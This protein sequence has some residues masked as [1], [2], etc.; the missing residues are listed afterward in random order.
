MIIE[1]YKPWLKECG[2]VKEA[3]RRGWFITW[4]PERIKGAFNNGN[5][6]KKDLKKY[7]DN[8]KALCYFMEVKK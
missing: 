4:T 5:G 2:S 6:T 8:N 7:M 3:M 1:F